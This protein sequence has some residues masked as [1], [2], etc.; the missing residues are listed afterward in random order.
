MPHPIRI[1]KLKHFLSLAVLNSMIK[2]TLLINLS[3]VIGTLALSTS[4]IYSQNVTYYCFGNGYDYELETAYQALKC[5]SNQCFDQLERTR[6]IDQD[7]YIDSILVHYLDSLEQMADGLDKVKVPMWK[8]HYKSTGIAPLTFYGQFFFHKSKEVFFQIKLSLSYETGGLLRA[9]SITVLTDNFP[10]SLDNFQYQYD[11][12][13]GS[14]T[15]FS[16]PPPPPPV[17]PVEE[18]F[19]LSLIPSIYKNGRINL[20]NAC[21]VKAVAIDADHLYWLQENYS[22]EYLRILH[23]NRYLVKK[24]GL[25]GVIDKSNQV[26]IPLIY[27]D[28]F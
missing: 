24:D 20:C 28:L 14:K 12:D 7:T 25:S 23:D 2:S 9:D 18:I 27:D 4:A 22:Y 10:G 3:I 21:Q 15:N 11:Y 5:I 16:F 26:I 8:K 1:H 17:P 13:N 6:F 19:N